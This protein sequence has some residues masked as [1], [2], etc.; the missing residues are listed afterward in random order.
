MPKAKYYFF[1]VLLRVMKPQFFGTSGYSL[2][3][4]DPLPITERIRRLQMQLRIDLHNHTIDII[5]M[6]HVFITFTKKVAHRCGLGFLPDLPVEES[7]TKPQKAAKT[8]LDIFITCWKCNLEWNSLNRIRGGPIPFSLLEILPFYTQ[9][10]PM[11]PSPELGLWKIRN[12]LKDQSSTLNVKK[13]KKKKNMFYQPLPAPSQ[14][15]SPGMLQFVSVSQ[16]SVPPFFK[17]Y[18]PKIISA[19]TDLPHSFCCEMFER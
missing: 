14:F 19:S 10:L 9:G 2:S 6:F 12:N 11:L 18:W 7:S 17:W 1:L 13:H 5:S 8:L 16:P 3:S 15:F 4:P